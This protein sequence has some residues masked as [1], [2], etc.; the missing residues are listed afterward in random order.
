MEPV[1]QRLK[2]RVKTAGILILATLSFVIILDVVYY[3]AMTGSYGQLE[4]NQVSQ[5]VKQIHGALQ[6]QFNAL[7][8]KL[9]RWAQWN[10]TYNFM[11]NTNSSYVYIASNLLHNGNEMPPA[12][13]A[14]GVNYMLFLNST[15]SIVY[16]IGYDL[17]N[18]TI[19]HIP[20]NFLNLVL[21]QA[22]MWNFRDLNSSFAGIVVIPQGPLL[23]V[24]RPVLTSEATGPIH[25]ALIFARSI[26]KQFI[27]E[28]SMT[29]NLPLVL[30]PYKT[31][32]PRVMS[33]AVFISPSTY[34]YPSNQT[35]ITGYYL[36]KDFNGQPAFLIGT[37]LP[38]TIYDQGL[39]SLGFLD[40]AVA[41]A[42]VI[43]VII[44]LV[45]VERTILLRLQKLVS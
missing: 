42:C 28:L 36:A 32:Q 13:G 24:S 17:V 27:N 20:A 43:F 40:L 6:D 14:F 8:S 35:S 38:R 31:F 44:T 11:V 5:T 19:V 22:Q 1:K 33:S 26:D 9:T 18:L 3:S 10:D 15:G 7:N 25:G 21:N 37:T 39:A 41:I 34:I 12:M 45:L 16:G 2:L 4:S 23:V 30:T 29:L